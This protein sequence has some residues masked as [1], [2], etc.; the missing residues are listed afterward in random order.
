VTGRGAP[1]RPWRPR[2]TGFKADVHHPAGKPGGPRARRPDVVTEVAGSARRR[3]CGHRGLARDTKPCPPRSRDGRGGGHLGAGRAVHAPGHRLRRD[4][5]RPGRLGDRI[6][7]QRRRCSRW[8][9][10][11]GGRAARWVNTH[12]THRFSRPGPARPAGAQAGRELPAD[13]HRR[14][15]QHA[16][17]G[18]AGRRG[19]HTPCCAGRSFPA[20]RPLDPAR[21]HAAGAARSARRRRKCWSRSGSDHLPIRARLSLGLTPAATRAQ[22]RATVDARE[23]VDGPGAAG[24][25]SQRP[26]GKPD[27]ASA[28][29]PGREDQRAARGP[30]ASPVHAR[31][32]TGASEADLEAGR[33][34]TPPSR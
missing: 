9:A 22:R 18:H 2:A 7:P 4:R 32:G 3:R 15:P 11:G 14:R 28:A 8:A 1:V 20:G 21:P 24:R 30:R 29:G 31:P 26:R 33:G 17:R 27:P 12:L 25:A 6:G 13:R 16:P 34:P 23:H 5:A 19:L 10:P